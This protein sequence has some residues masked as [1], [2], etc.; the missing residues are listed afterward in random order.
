MSETAESE[1]ENTHG[2]GRPAREPSKRRP[3]WVVVS[4]SL[5]AALVVAFVIFHVATGGAMGRH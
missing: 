1:P 2:A 4:W 3:R 5:M